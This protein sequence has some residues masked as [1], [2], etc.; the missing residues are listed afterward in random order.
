VHLIKPIKR[1]ELQDTI[2]SI[3][4][5]G[6]EGKNSATVPKSEIPQL[7]LRILVA[8]DNPTSQLIARKTL[9][10]MGCRVE[11]AGN[12]VEATRLAQ[13][14]GFDLV[15]MDFEMPEM[16]GLEATRII[17]GREKETHKHLPIVAMTAYAMKQDR[18]KC[19]EAGM[20]GYITKPVSPENLY[21]AIKGIMPVEVKTSEPPAVD[22]EAALR[23]VGGDLDILNEVLQ[24]FLKEDTPKL[25]KN[26]DADILRQDGKALKAE[27]HGMKGASAAMGGQ[28]IA[29][30]ASRL[31]T[32]ALNGDMTSARVIYGEMV[33]EVERLK[34]Y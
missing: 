16:N 10:K 18:D 3:L 9:E 23:T 28:A 4:S 31:E 13:Q 25:L 26:I 14:G 22:I 17:R 15:L 7:K 19:F 20:D 5:T 2:V 24:V 6:G 8:E 21:N 29:A 34:D 32:A 30:A 12:G 27:A 1:L 33:I 11:I